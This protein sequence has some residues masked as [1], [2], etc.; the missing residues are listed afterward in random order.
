LIGVGRPEH[1]IFTLTSSADISA[2]DSRA[3][4]TLRQQP[5]LDSVRKSDVRHPFRGD[6]FRSVANIRH[7]VPMVPDPGQTLVASVALD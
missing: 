1:T 7:A 3:G 5:M 2:K 6:R 4:S